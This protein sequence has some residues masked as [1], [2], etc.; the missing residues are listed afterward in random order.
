MDLIHLAQAG[1]EE[2]LNQLV[3]AHMPLVQALSRRFSYCE[4]AFQQG[5][6]GLVKAIRNF[7][8]ETGNQ[9]STYAVPVILGEMRRTRR[10]PLGWRR[11][12]A[13]RR[14]GAFR[15]AQL[16]RTGQEPPLADIA[17]A[18]G[19]EKAELM[20]LMEMDQPP[21]YDDTG[22][23]LAA[24]PVKAVIRRVNW[25]RLMHISDASSS[26]SSRPRLR[27]RS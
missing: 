8:P 17:R 5:C 27:C 18:A 16:R 2:A 25:E 23:L 13:L 20:L 11:R 4:D 1:N 21:V 7:R 15:E 10:D 14:A 3:R 26:M 24:M 22:E 9:F 6:V 19:V 12:A